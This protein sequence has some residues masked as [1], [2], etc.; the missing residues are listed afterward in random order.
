MC[1]AG[2]GDDPP[3]QRG[4]RRRRSFVADSPVVAFAH[5]TVDL[6]EDR[7]LGRVGQEDGIDTATGEV[8]PVGVG[9]YGSTHDDGDP[10]GVTIP[11]ERV[12]VPVELPRMD[13]DTD[14]IGVLLDRRGCQRRR[15]VERSEVDDFESC[16]EEELTHREGSDLVLI[17]SQHA[18]HDTAAVVMIGPAISHRNGRRRS[19]RGRT[20]R[21]DDR[22]L[23]AGRR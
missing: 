8:G 19:W 13:R 15:R 16:P 7:R 10:G 1:G 14:D 5:E 12:D 17:E 21:R 2:D 6:V 22:S 18:D 4:C 3:G 11:D 9:E 23:R 20:D